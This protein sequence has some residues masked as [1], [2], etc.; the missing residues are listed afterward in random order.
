MLGLSSG[1]LIDVERGP[2]WL[3]VR[4]GAPGGD[5]DCDVSSLADSIWSV[6]EQHFV[7]RIVLECDRLHLV[8]SAMIAQLIG[9]HRRLQ[10]HGGVLRL[11]G[12]SDRNQEM[13]RA[14]RLDGLFPQFRDRSQ[15]VL[16]HRPVRPR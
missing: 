15:A 9:L 7:Y 2:D 3:F 6:V 5:A 11:S 1:W 10:K 16:A 4:F 13:L 14:C 12:L 8:D